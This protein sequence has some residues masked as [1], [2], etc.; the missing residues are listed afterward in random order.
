MQSREILDEYRRMTN[1]ERWL[2]TAQL[3]R[4]NT[5][6]LLEGPAAVVERRFEPL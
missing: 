3:I 4:E 6:A 1:A 2:L 5:P